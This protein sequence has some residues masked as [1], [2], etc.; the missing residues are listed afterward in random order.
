MSDLRLELQPVTAPTQ[1]TAPDAARAAEPATESAATPPTPLRPATSAATR[2][3]GAR[4]R[5]ADDAP[6]AQDGAST[7]PERAMGEGPWRDW[8]RSWET[9]SYRLP[10]ELVDELTERL[11]QLRIRDIGVPIAAAITHML[12]LDDDEILALIER[13]DGAKPRRRSGRPPLT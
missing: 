2:P 12:D 9:R 13:A 5:S 6:R 4:P 11:W 3:R 7:E 10:P 8:Q 1:A